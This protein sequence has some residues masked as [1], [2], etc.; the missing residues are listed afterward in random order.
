[1]LNIHVDQQQISTIE[2]TFNEYSMCD[3]YEQFM[4]V[5]DNVFNGYMNSNKKGKKQQQTIL[6]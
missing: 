6:E 2:C 3:I 1:M 4:H 5:Y